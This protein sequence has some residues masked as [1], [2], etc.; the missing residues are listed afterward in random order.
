MS[1]LVNTKPSD[2]PPLLPPLHHHPLRQT[3]HSPLPP[4]STPRVRQ[5][6]IIYRVLNV[7]RPSPLLGVLLHRSPPLESNSPP[8]PP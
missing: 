5:V 6:T 3:P 4:T 2:L 7:Y 1:Q 8:F